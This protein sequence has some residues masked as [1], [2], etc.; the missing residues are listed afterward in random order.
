VQNAFND[1]S[2]EKLIEALIEIWPE[3]RACLETYY[4][5]K[6]PC[7]YKIWEEEEGCVVAVIW[8]KEGGKMGC[9]FGKISYEA[10]QHRYILSQLSQEFPK[11][12]IFAFVDDSDSA[13]NV[14]ENLSREEAIEL[15]TNIK[16][17]IK[18]KKE[19]AASLNMQLAE[20][21]GKL[22]LPENFPLEVDDPIL[23]GLNATKE[24]VSVNGIPIGKESFIASFLENKLQGV[25]EYLVQVG[26][27]GK[28]DPQM[29]SRILGESCNH[30]FDYTAKAVEPVILQEEV[31]GS[32]DSLI[33][34]VQLDV[35]NVNDQ[36]PMISHEGLM[37]ATQ[38]IL[39]MPVKNGGFGLTPLTVKAPA[40][41][42]STVVMMREDKKLAKKVPLFKNE[43]SGTYDR[44]YIL[45]KVDSEAR[46]EMKAYIP[47]RKDA[48]FGKKAERHTHNGKQVANQLTKII[49]HGR[50]SSFLQR[51]ALQPEVFD[52]STEDSIRIMT[53]CL[54]SQV[55][56]VL[57]VDLTEPGNR[58]EAQAFKAFFSFFLGQHPP[59]NGGMIC[60]KD[61]TIEN[62][63]QRCFFGHSELQVM[64]RHGNHVAAC[65]SGRESTNATHNQIRDLVAGKLEKIG[66]IAETEPPTTKVMEHLV[67]KEEC[68][69]FFKKSRLLPL[70]QKKD[71][72]EVKHCQLTL[73]MK[74]NSDGSSLTESQE[75]E[76]NQRLASLKCS[77]PFFMMDDQDDQERKE[78]K[79]GLRLDV[80]FMQSTGKKDYGLDVTVIH[81]LIAGYEGIDHKNSLKMLKD[82]AFEV[83]VPGATEEGRSRKATPRMEKAVKDKQT[84]YRALEN[85]ANKLHSCHRRKRKLHFLPLGVSHLGEMSSGWFEMEDILKG[86]IKGA[87]RFKGRLDGISPSTLAAQVCKEL[88]DSVMVGLVQGWG[89]QLLETGYC[90]RNGEV[91]GK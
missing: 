54:R 89:T 44:L 5:G 61:G 8:S 71:L 87:G 26:E 23:E 73:L 91:R 74:K 24:G 69:F 63:V 40:N 84:K 11:T 47:E 57:R 42:W 18:R 28:N 52:L 32:F 66:L 56:R 82:L 90:L 15:I 34:E 36:L 2:R 29:A 39:E 83:L 86:Y 22:L 20:K 60:K 35:I 85:L 37:M 12:D 78:K 27:L 50:T 4:A 46:E 13:W 9:P 19:L 62:V 14:P 70:E 17:F 31:G 77:L 53:I 68:K 16:F 88:K 10:G 51:V 79:K 21:K 33:Q 59:A 64:D 6:S 76:I 43:I 49:M 55:T 67:S 30:A 81:P 58:V 3:A 65:A 41:Y 1:A 75:Q 48:L 25:Q 80:H 72:E 38:E 7:F 45:S